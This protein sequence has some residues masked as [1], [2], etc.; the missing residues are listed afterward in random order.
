MNSI[1]LDPFRIVRRPR[2][3]AL[4][5]GL[6]P[7]LGGIQ[8]FAFWLRFDGQLGPTEMALFWSMLPWCLAIKTM[9]LAW[10]G[11]HENWNGFVS[12]H[13]L[14][15]LIKGAT[16]GSVLLALC[17]YLVFLDDNV[18]RSVFLMDWVMTI[19]VVGGLRSVGRMFAER[20]LPH[21]LET[22]KTPVLIVGANNSG[23]ALLR[24]IRRDSRLTYRVIGFISDDA[25]HP[26]GRIGGIPILGHVDQTCALAEKLRV[27]EVLITAGELSGKQVRQLELIVNRSGY[28]TGNCS[29]KKRCRKR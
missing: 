21:F 7:I 20:E 18:P 10:F 15:A 24:M 8:Y 2:Q 25:S 5:A 17:D 28:K 26:G 3:A 1:S 9:A 4:L 6:M 11:V 14:V 19:V 16:I 22:G 13:E 23:E 12:F 29:G 27:Q